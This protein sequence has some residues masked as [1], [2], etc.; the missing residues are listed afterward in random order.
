[1][2]SETRWQDSLPQNYHHF[3][4]NYHSLLCKNSHRFGVITEAPYVYLRMAPPSESP[5]P[6]FYDAEGYAK[7]LIGQVRVYV[8]CNVSAKSFHTRHSWCSIWVVLWT[9][10]FRA[11]CRD[12]SWPVAKDF[13]VQRTPELLLSVLL[14]SRSGGCLSYC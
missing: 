2:Q 12:S 8:E 7:Q 4:G 3:A 1:M 5:Q 11:C 10:L 9:D 13:S 14:G 6:T